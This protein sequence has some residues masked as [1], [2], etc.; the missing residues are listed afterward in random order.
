MSAP[1]HVRRSG[2]VSWEIWSWTKCMPYIVG[3]RSELA[4][5]ELARKCNAVFTSL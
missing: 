2:P 1:F 4:A 5:R 3:I